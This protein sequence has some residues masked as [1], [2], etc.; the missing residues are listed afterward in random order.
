[1]SVVRASFAIFSLGVLAACGGGG[2]GGGLGGDSPAPVGGDYEPGVFQ[3][4]STFANLC[5]RPR[6]GTNPATN[7]PF[8]D[9]AGTRVDENNFLRSWTNE[10][11]LWYREV[12]DLNP[13]SYQTLEYFD[14]LRTTAV[15]PSGTD[16]DQFHFTYDSFLWYQLSQAGVMF[17]YGAQ[18]IV[19]EQYPPRSIVV[20]FTEPNSPAAQAGVERGDEVLAIDGADAIYGNTQAIVA[21]LNEGLAPS[22]QQPHTFRMRKLSGQ[23]VTI[24]MTPDEIET[25]PVQNVTVLNQGTDPVG[26][27]VF[28]D[29]IATAEAQLVD[30]FETLRAASV[31]DLVLD[32]RYNGGGYLDMAAQVAYMIAGPA[33]TSGQIFERSE[34]N[35]KHTTTN[36]VTGQP[37][38]PTP[39]HTTTLGFGEL[40]P[41]R[42]LPTLNLNRVYVLTSEST[43]SAS[44][45][46]INGLRGVG[47]EVYQIG[48]RTCGK[49]YGFYPRDNCGT[50]YF[51]IQFQG[52]NAKDYGDYADGF[53]PSNDP[54]P[55]DAGARLPGCQVGDDFKHAL[56][57]PTE[58]RLAAALGFRSSGNLQCPAPSSVAPGAQLKT[59][60]QA[61]PVD[62]TLIRSPL[63]ENR[64]LRDW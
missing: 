44:E 48:T 35:D 8:L 27:L 53:A 1:M 52:K 37:L 46:I 20:A 19:L 24:T 62:G 45:A 50:T 29:H 64:I 41:N 15:T 22:I 14:L 63:R 33:L 36:P 4:S 18:W 56:G 43:C 12:P 54:F 11:Y 28:N 6:T 40:E 49:P 55:V 26:Y 3:P 9:R 39:F 5:A 34:F 23:E 13:R 32:L 16:K 7:A 60:E 59:G 61:A 31:N 10:T 38:T 58:A 57:D 21:A 30:A 2:G 51:T 17:G 47:V 25:T 42:S